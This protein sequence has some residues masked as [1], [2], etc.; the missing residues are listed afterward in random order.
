VTQLDLS[1]EACRRRYAALLAAARERAGTPPAIPSPG[2][3]PPAAVVLRESIPPGWYWT[4]RLKRGEALRIANP[5]GAAG[6]AALFWNADDP[7]ERYNPAD[8]MKVQWTARVRA[9]LV[10]LS[11]MGRAL[12]SVI[13]DSDGVHDNLIGAGQPAESG[14]N[15]R[16]NFVLAA[17]KHGLDARDVGPCISFFAGVR[18]ADGGALAWDPAAAR[19]GA[20]IDLRAEMNLLVA[21]S[22]CAHPLAP[23]GAPQAS[24]D[25][26][27]WQ[28]PAAAADDPCRTAGPEAARAF[29]NTERLFR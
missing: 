29:E 7:T 26:A 24:V 18:V 11:D 21:L 8:T 27:I 19:A 2:P 13:A 22:N 9:G 15:S 17:A 10:L 16:E 25:V 5:G 20:A 12:A 23:A 14:R 1:P 4:G 6:V 3:L 28:P